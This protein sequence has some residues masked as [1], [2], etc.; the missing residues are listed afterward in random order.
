LNLVIHI[1]RVFDLVFGTLH[2][3]HIPAL[4][5]A[6]FKQLV[7]LHIASSQFGSLWWSLAGGRRDEAWQE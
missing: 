2:A 5:Q 7:S 6:D 1:R 3:K 4:R